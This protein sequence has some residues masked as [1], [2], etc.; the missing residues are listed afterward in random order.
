MADKDA[1][2]EPVKDP[3]PGEPGYYSPP[4]VDA[5][6]TKSFPNERPAPTEPGVAGK[7]GDEVEDYEA[8]TVPELKEL[9]QQRGIEA[10]SD[11]LKDD[12]VQALKKT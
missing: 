10:H 2:P 1:K 6:V 4:S 7:S 12:Y 8:L 3:E 11:W 9:A 5:G